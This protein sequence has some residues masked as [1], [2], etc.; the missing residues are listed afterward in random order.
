MEKL[1]EGQIINNKELVEMFGTEKNKKYYKEKRKVTNTM[2]KHILRKA[3]LYIEIKDLTRG[4]Y[5]IE[6]VY[7]QEQIKINKE[8]LTYTRRQYE[9]SQ[10]EIKLKNDKDKGV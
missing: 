8:K 9:H 2:K 4:K 6:K 1:K 3:N 7:T 5:L 10:C